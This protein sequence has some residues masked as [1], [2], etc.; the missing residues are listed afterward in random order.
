MMFV[1]YAELLLPSNSN[2]YTAW[3][4]DSYSQAHTHALLSFF[5]TFFAKHARKHTHTQSTDT[6]ELLHVF[7]KEHIKLTLMCFLPADN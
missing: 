4:S 6:S 1:N 7:N 2:V 5:F 3:S